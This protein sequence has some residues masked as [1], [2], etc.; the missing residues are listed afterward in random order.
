MALY[1]GCNAQ[2]DMSCFI[3][4]NHAIAEME[5]SLY[6]YSAPTSPSVPTILLFRAAENYAYHDT[7]VNLPNRLALEQIIDAKLTQ[8]LDTHYA[9]ALID[10]N[11]FADLNAVLGQEHGDRLLIAI[12]ERLK[13]ALNP[14]AK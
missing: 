6:K 13:I 11:H 4:N 9:L 8:E 14:L 5:Q 1:L 3:A 10:I 12:A 7:L 2:G